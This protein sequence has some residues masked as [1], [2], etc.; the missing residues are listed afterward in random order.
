M[1]IRTAVFGFGVSGRYFHAPF[2][3]TDPAYSLDFVVTAN[4]QR[5]AQ[6]RAFAPDVTVLAD[7]DALLRRAGEVDLLVIGT[8][9]ATHTEIAAAALDAGMHVV[10]DKPFAVSSTAA[11]ELLAKARERERVLTVYQ[12]RR[13][14]DDFQAVRDLV[15]SGELGRIHTFESRFES[16]KPQGQ[17]D[18]KATTGVADGGGILFDLGPH[19]LDQARQLF[20]PVED[21]WADVVTRGGGADDDTMVVL[22]HANGTRSRI[23]LSGFAALPG[24]RFHVLGSRAACTIWGTDPQEAMLRAGSLPGD[25]GFGVREQRYWAAVGT[26]EQERRVR[27]PRGDYAAFYTRLAQALNGTA[28]PP[29]D[30]QDAVEVLRLIEQAHRQSWPGPPA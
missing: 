16:W 4:A 22:R 24:P 14:D 15:D 9:P 26:P 17:R 27:P 3:C 18:W 23:F 10:V 20:G 30:P 12:N 11:A 28:E 5:A 7:L 21:L 19:L 8:P 25:E 13:W 6:A 1:S 2:L 29:V